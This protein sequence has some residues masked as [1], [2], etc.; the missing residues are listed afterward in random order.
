MISSLRIR[1]TM[2]SPLLEMT[3]TWRAVVR[4]VSAATVLTTSLN[5]QSPQ[6][7]EHPLTDPSLRTGTLPNGMRYYIRANAMPPQRALL[8]LAVKAGSIQEDDDQRGFAHFVEHMAFNGTANFP[9]NT[10]ID[11]LE[12]AGM[13]FGAD[14]NAHTSFDETV[15]KLTVPT[16][17]DIT[18]QRGFQILEDWAGG[19]VLFD[20]LDVV[21]ERG[22]VLGE[23]RVRLPDTLSE[24]LQKDELRRMFG[25]GSRYVDRLPIGLPELIRKADPAPL[26]RY[27]RDW[28]RPDLMAIIAVGDFDPEAV[29]KLILERFGSIPAHDN[30]RHFEYPDIPTFGTTVVQ[31]VR[32]KVRPQINMYWPAPPMPSDAEGAIR[33]HLIDLILMRELGDRVTRLTKLER[34]PFAAGSAGRSPSSFENMIDYYS[35]ALAAV[36]DSLISGF[37]TMLTEVERLAQHGLPAGTLERHKGVLLREYEGT[38]DGSAALSS[39]RL[40]GTYTMHYLRG[41]GVLLSPQQALD[42]ARK[43]LPTIEP[44]TI[45]KAA[46]TWRSAN[47]RVVTITFHEFS[48]VRSPTESEVV[49]ILDSIAGST[50]SEAAPHFAATNGEFSDNDSKLLNSTPVAGKIVSALHA[51][52]VGVTKWTLSNGAQVVYKKTTADPDRVMIHAYSLGGHSLLPDSLFYSPGRLVPM[53]MTSSGGLGEK[54]HD[55]LVRDLGT[56]GVRSLRVELNA[57]DEEVVV[58]G[59]PRELETLFQLMYLQFTAPTIDTI[60]LAEWRRTGGQTLTMSQND[61]IAMQTGRIRRLVPPQVAS[62]PFIDLDQAMRVYKDRFGD[63]SDF[64]FYIVGAAESEDVQRFVERYIAS[65][66]SQHRTTPETPRS[67]DIPV[68]TEPVIQTVRSPRQLPER[69]AANIVFNGKLPSDSSSYLSTVEEL[70]AIQR[71]LGRRL[72][73]RLREDMAVTY[74]VGVQLMTYETPDPRYAF[75]INLTT[76]PEMMDTSVAVLWREI[77]TFRT[78]GPTD[79]EL[80]MSSHISRRRLENARLSNVWWI[81]QLQRYDRLGVSFDRLADLE[82]QNPT[83]E[84]IRSTMRKYLSADVYTQQ[85]VLPMKKS[86]KKPVDSEEDSEKSGEE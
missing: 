57:F 86:S 80:A 28:Y 50:V 22:V 10:L 7:H 25:S 45:A 70:G 67:F 48:P 36:P 56:T 60:S 24:R 39:Q 5:A 79:E 73:N 51:E 3:R 23:W 17:D 42:L 40:V 68:P 19:K 74:G 9:G 31:V 54:S 53:L 37:Q 66:P 44:E 15:Y 30:P 20:S 14:L 85:I 84:E 58:A 32:D 41:R 82:T 4:I 46:R 65:L 21:G 71:I 13:S 83:G 29:E 59:S 61:Q 18:L 27:Y 1:D 8:W 6:G 64:T 78:S 49:A 33:Q 35:I 2:C 38:V 26:Q 75:V 12:N 47:G 16:D 72:R 34:R 62:V 43:I 76:A 52:K 69:A 77:E 55:D 11:V 81:H 63:A